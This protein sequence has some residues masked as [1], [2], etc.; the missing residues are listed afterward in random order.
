MS[1]RYELRFEVCDEC[2][3]EYHKNTFN[4]INK[5]AKWR[6]ERGILKPELRQQWNKLWAGNLPKVPCLFVYG[7]DEG[8]ATSLCLKHLNQA[9]ESLQA[10]KEEVAK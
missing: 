10:L 5:E 1:G 7:G 6:D 3:D 4:E 9:L 2:W 8:V